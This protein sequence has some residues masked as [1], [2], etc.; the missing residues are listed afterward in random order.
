MNNAE[1]GILVMLEIKCPYCG[2]ENTLESTEPEQSCWYCHN[3]VTFECSLCRKNDIVDS[4]D[5]YDVLD[6]KGDILLCRNC[7]KND[8][9]GRYRIYQIKIKFREILKDVLETLA[10]SGTVRF[11]GI[12]SVMIIFWNWFP[13]I[14][15]VIFA[16]LLHLIVIIG[17]VKL[18][19]KK[20]KNK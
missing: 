2:H 19:L 17:F 16:I 8:L 7:K 18:I 15:I 14:S 9:T 13:K 12:L 3:K 6:K 4:Y 5:A 20:R 10:E 11:V 1:T